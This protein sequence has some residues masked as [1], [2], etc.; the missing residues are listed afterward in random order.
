MA[1]SAPFD[2]A[3]T[4]QQGAHA[5]ASFDAAKVSGADLA[6]TVDRPGVTAAAGPF[7][8]VRAQLVSE[9]APLPTGL[10]VGRADARL[11]GGPAGPHR[12]QVADRAGA[13]HPV[14]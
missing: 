12:R 2:R 8:A 7:D 11:D 3:F 4:H 6:A 5:T 13:D 1:S 10:I 14:P 9:S